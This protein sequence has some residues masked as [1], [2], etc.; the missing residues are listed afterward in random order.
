[1]HLAEVN[2]NVN[3]IEKQ[4]SRIGERLRTY[5][6]ELQ[7]AQRLGDPVSINLYSG[8]IKSNAKALRGYRNLMKRFRRATV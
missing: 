7:R 4:M 6:A 5:T 3:Y 1:M 8:L 2:G